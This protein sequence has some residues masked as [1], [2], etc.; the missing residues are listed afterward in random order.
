MPARKKA[1]ELMSLSEITRSPTKNTDK[2]RRKD[3]AIQQNAG[4]NT[5]NDRDRRMTTPEDGLQLGTTV[6]L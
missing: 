6:L 3:Y 4:P 1:A 5:R 2:N